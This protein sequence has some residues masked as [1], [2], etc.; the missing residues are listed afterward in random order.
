MYGPRSAY[1]SQTLAEFDQ[2]HK[3]MEFQRQLISALAAPGVRR[4]L[5]AALE[6]AEVEGKIEAHETKG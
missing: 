3:D 5:R 4:A 6:L 2:R 1:S